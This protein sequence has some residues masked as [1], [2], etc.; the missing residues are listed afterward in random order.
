MSFRGTMIE[1]AASRV[2]ISSLERSRAYKAY[3]AHLK[4]AKD[5]KELEGDEVFARL[6]TE[7]QD[8]KQ[9]HIVAQQAYEAVKACPP[10]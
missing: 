9:N 6:R 1:R 2:R 8:A 4:E 7:M 5:T 3:R 10:F